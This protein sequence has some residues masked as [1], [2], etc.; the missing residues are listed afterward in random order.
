MESLYLIVGNEILFEHNWRNRSFAKIA[1]SW[2]AQTR[3]AGDVSPVHEISNFLVFSLRGPMTVL[4]I[5]SKDIDAAYGIEFLHR[6]LFVFEEY[7][8]S[9]IQNLDTVTEI[10]CEMFDYSHTLTMEPD[11]LKDLVLPPSLLNKLM[12]VAGM[13]SKY[14]QQGQLSNIPWRRAK[15]KYTNNE[16]FVD[17]VEDLK[18]VVDK[19][20]RFVTSDVSGRLQCTAKLSGTPEVTATLKSK[21]LLPLLHPCVDRERFGSNGTLVFTPPDGKFTLLSYSTEL[22]TNRSSPLPFSIQFSQARIPDSFEVALSTRQGCP[23]SLCVE[24]PLPLSCKGV[25]YSTSRGDC[26]VKTNASTLLQWMLTGL[27]TKSGTTRTTLSCTNVPGG[28]KQ[29]SYS[30]VTTTL[31]NQ[32]ISGLKIDSLKIH[33]AGDWKPYKGVKYTTTANIVFRVW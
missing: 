29:L 30:R 9:A 19:N 15:V 33:R 25:R 24:I 18:A 21:V 23:D 4:C 5:A 10:L 31:A 1:E 22:S 12:N 28:L 2:I 27:S 14:E 8:T 3:K 6:I 16:I 11:A 17:V 32:A 20:G 7:F 26:V 13:Q